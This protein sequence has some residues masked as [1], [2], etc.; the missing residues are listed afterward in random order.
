MDLVRQLSCKSLWMSVWGVRTG[1]RWLPD[2][3]HDGLRRRTLVVLERV[4]W[5]PVV[6]PRLADRAGGRVAEDTIREIPELNACC[7]VDEDR[8]NAN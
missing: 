2:L 6:C 7:A 3:L 1:Y 4:V 8:W 5:Q